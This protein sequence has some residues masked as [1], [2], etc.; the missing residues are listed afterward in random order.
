MLCLTL[1]NISFDSLSLRNTST[2]R[3]VQ[4]RGAKYFHVEDIRDWRRGEDGREYLRWSN[5]KDMGT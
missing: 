3:K 1:D 2:A 4:V 5:G